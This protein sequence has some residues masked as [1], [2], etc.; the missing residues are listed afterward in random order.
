MTFQSGF[1]TSE[2]VSLG[3]FPLSGAMQWIVPSLGNIKDLLSSEQN[4]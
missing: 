3:S 1:Y 4:A 2:Q